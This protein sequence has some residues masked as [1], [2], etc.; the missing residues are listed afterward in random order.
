MSTT[1]TH[2][3]VSPAL[4]RRAVTAAMIGNA[5]EWYDYVTYGNLATITPPTDSR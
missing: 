1:D 3:E 5:A 2:Y 4:H